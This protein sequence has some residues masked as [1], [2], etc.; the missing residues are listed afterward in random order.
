MAGLISF[1]S[2]KAALHVQELRVLHLNCTI[3]EGEGEI[4]SDFEFLPTFPELRELTLER[5]D[6]VS[7]SLMEAVLAM[8]KLEQLRFIQLQ[9]LQSSDAAQLAKKARAQR[10]GLRIAW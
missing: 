2:C 5:L 3:A 8:P 7:D 4:G 1:Q 9:D 6:C 10:P